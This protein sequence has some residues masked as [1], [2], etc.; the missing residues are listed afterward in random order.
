[1]KRIVAFQV[2]AGVILLSVTAGAVVHVPNP[3]S[4]KAVFAGDKLTAMEDGARLVA[5]EA[6]MITGTKDSQISKIEESNPA[7]TR[8]ELTS[9]GFRVHVGSKPVVIVLGDEEIE[10]RSAELL[11]VSFEGGW[12]VDV[13]A[14]SRGGSIQIKEGAQPP[15]PGAPI[16][17]APGQDPVTAQAFAKT[18][19]KEFA[20]RLTEQPRPTKLR[21]QDIETPSDLATAKG[22][23]SDE[24]VLE[25]DVIEIEVES[26]C[27]EVC[28]D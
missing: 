18:H 20:A 19:L 26:D 5:G 25:I 9:G 17:L 22:G 1:M 16:Q 14:L 21:L 11:I 2:F 24:S 3:L 8:V 13:V 4:E 6:V 10:T 7:A 23:E 28:V 12:T 15:N 27:V